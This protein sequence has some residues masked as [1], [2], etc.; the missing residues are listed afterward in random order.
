MKKKVLIFTALLFSAFAIN[1]QNLT[2]SYSGGN[3]AN[4]GSVTIGGELVS[5]IEGHIYF[6]NNS[7]STINV[8][9]KK[10]EISLI[11]GSDN[12]F[13]FNGSC[14]PPFVYVSPTALSLT[15]G[16]TNSTSFYGDYTSNGNPGI[17]TVAYTF[18]N[19][20]N[21]NDSAQVI[22]NYDATAG[23]NGH[24]SL[25]TELSNAFPN[26]ANSYVSF[27]YS[28]GK[29]VSSAKVVLLDLLGTEIRESS[30]TEPEGKVVFSTSDISNG[31]YFYAFVINDKKVISRKLV[32]KHQ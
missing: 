16:T 8:M 3:I 10:T 14:Y 5:I 29:D 11:A 1:A 31:V 13:C 4:G 12:S 27:N 15:A 6:T 25:K 2:L 26:P 32:I 24:V 28:F 20:S 7:A 19:Q 9:V 17:S 22:V 18:Y 21:P 30:V 23:I